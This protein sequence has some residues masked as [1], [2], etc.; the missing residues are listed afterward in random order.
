MTRKKKNDFEG[1]WCLFF[2][3]IFMFLVVFRGDVD[4]AMTTFFIIF[5]ILPIVGF[6]IWFTVEE[7]T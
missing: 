5:I 1:L 6:V 2:S 4:A 3:I 7:K